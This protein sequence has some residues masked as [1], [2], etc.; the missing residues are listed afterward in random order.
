MGHHGI[1]LHMSGARTNPNGSNQ[2]SLDPRQRMC[3]DFYVN[4]K[5][6]TFGNA[7]RSA[8]KA[9][10]EESHANTITDTQWFRDRVRRL[11]MLSKAEKVLEETLDMEDVAKVEL[12]T[13]VV[14]EKR[15]PALTRIKQDTAK[16][17]AERLG[18]ND[19]YS[20]RS[21]LSGPD[22]Q[23]VEIESSE[24]KDLANKLNALYTRTN[25]TSDGTHSDP[26]DSEVQN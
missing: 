3:W 13:G 7:L 18:K 26:V 15:D 10:Y 17:L 14:L 1:I 12:S 23:P 24:L 4:P 22:G 5:S 25:I 2:Y 16:F 6:E 8:I 21:E 19:G 11:N 20:S 9:G